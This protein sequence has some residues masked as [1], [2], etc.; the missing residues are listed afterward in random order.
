MVDRKSRVKDGVSHAPTNITGIKFMDVLFQYDKPLF[1]NFNFKI[2]PG[3]TALIGESG[4]GKT[5]IISL[6]MRFYDIFGGTIYLESGGLDFDLS[7][8]TNQSLIERIGYVGQEPV[9]I[10][11]TLK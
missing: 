6:I 2:R 3:M 7:K 10:G 4:S 1:K 9:L 8:L 5:T 11:K